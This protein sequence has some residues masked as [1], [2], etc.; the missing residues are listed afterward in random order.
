MAGVVADVNAPIGIIKQV[1]TSISDV[2]K[3]VTDKSNFMNIFGIVFTIV[4][5]VTVAMVFVKDVLIWIIIDIPKWLFDGPWAKLFKFKPGEQEGAGVLPFIVRYIIVIFYKVISLPKCFLWYFLD[6]AGWIMY[7]PFRFIFW[8]IDW[9][10]KIGL[11]KA[12]IKAWDFMDQIDYFVHGRPKDNY[13]MY[14][15]KPSSNTTDSDGKPLV[16]GK[17]PNTL[18]LGFHII[19]FPDSVMYQCYAITPFSLWNFPPFPMKN[20]NK[21]MNVKT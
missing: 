18:Q 9:L 21:L 16:N 7:L 1:Q 6:T 19:H 3:K 13:F 12:E 4:T 17:D 20:F 2:L 11:V 14:Q 5:I 8:A 15:Y 10:L